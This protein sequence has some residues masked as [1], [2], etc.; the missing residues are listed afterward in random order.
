MQHRHFG[1]VRTAATMPE[2][3]VEGGTEAFGDCLMQHPSGLE[4]PWTTAHH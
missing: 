3:G 2:G 1:R 4:T